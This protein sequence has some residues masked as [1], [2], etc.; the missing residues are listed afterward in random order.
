MQDTTINPN[1]K[2][3]GSHLHCTQT[4][5]TVTI[6]EHGDYWNGSEWIEG[7]FIQYPWGSTH[8]IHVDRVGKDYLPT[9]FTL[10]SLFEV[11]P[12]EP[13]VPDFVYDLDPSPLG[14]TFRMAA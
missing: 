9:A 12:L 8:V 7:Y 14:F 5:S 3:V 13:S 2:L 11:Q 1:A 6:L 4:L 10:A